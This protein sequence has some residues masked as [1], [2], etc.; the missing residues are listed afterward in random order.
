[1]TKKLFWKDPYQTTCTAKVTQI[2]GNIIMLDQTIFYAFSGGQESDSGTING[3]KVIN[4]TKIGDK[5]N[6][7]DIEYLLTR[8]NF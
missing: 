7:I 6:I 3:I 5:E 1:M 4:A 8:F 2:N